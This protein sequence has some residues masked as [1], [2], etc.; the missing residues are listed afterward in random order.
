MTHAEIRVQSVFA[1]S[2][3]LLISLS[4]PLTSCRE[5]TLGEKVGDKIDDATDARPA[6]GLRDT[7]EDVR[8]E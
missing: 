3:L 2:L 4:L 7:I 1:A 5:R 8:R 6:E